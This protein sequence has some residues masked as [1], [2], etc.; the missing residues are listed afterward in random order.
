LGIKATQSRLNITSAPGEL[1]FQR[2]E[3]KP[4]DGPLYNV[5]FCLK[6]EKKDERTKNEQ[7]KKN[8]TNAE[9]TAALSCT[10]QN[11]SIIKFGPLQKIRQK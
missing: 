2:G 8:N 3:P 1:T 11:I 10:F 7:W 9:A 4:T 5:H 6:N